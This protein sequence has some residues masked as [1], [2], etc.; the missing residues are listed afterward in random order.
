MYPLFEEYDCQWMQIR[1][2]IGRSDS[3]VIFSL[4]WDGFPIPE[5]VI[6]LSIYPA[7][8]GWLT[9][10]C[11]IHM[12]WHCTD[13]LSS[14]V[15]LDKGCCA[16]LF[17][18]CLLCKDQ[19]KLSSNSN[20]DNTLYFWNWPRAHTTDKHTHTQASCLRRKYLPSPGLISQKGD[21]E[22]WLGGDLH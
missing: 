3:R 1:I 22:A 6:I 4:E 20:Y 2:E 8:S 18:S 9:P 21:W 15:C 5:M 7:Y 12:A 11:H 10:K 13:P 16:F 19:I 17:L 14:I